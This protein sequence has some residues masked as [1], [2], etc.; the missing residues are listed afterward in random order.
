[1]GKYYI[2]REVSEEEALR[3][4]VLC[5]A[6]D[7]LLSRL[8]TIRLG[9]TLPTHRWIAILL[10]GEKEQ[11]EYCICGKPLNHLGPCPPDGKPESCKA[12]KD[13]KP[14]PMGYDQVCPACG[15]S[16]PPA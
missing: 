9:P 10:H 15:R 4:D 14:D 6:E 12:C 3:S 2:I 16:V 13:M 1:M 5:I 11:S 7:D 8:A